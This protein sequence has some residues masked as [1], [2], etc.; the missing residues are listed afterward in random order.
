[1]LVGLA[2]ILLSGWVAAVVVALRTLRQRRSRPLTVARVRFAAW[3]AG[4]PAVRRRRHVAG[5]ARPHGRRSA[6]RARPAPELALASA[7]ARRGVRR[8]LRRSAQ[9]RDGTPNA[10]LG[11]R[12]VHRP[13]TRRARPGIV[14]PRGLVGVLGRPVVEMALL[15]AGLVTWVLA[16]THAGPS[17]P[18]RALLLIAGVVLVYAVD[19]AARA[20][21]QTGQPSVEA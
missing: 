9:R 10:A 8:S 19:G 16:V 15:V 14:R 13:R 3:H 20:Q 12:R 4:E 7:S 17:S 18:A 5:P 6:P 1:M 21:S 2:L 11:R